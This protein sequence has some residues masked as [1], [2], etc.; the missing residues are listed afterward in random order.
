MKKNIIILSW[1][2]FTINCHAQYPVIEMHFNGKNTECEKII[3]DTCLD[4][5]SMRLQYDSIII[6]ATLPKMYL[7]YADS[8]KF[9][10]DTSSNNGTSSSTYLRKTGQYVLSKNIP[11]VCISC[12]VSQYDI[13]IIFIGTKIFLDDSVKTTRWQ[14]NYAYTGGVWERNGVTSNITSSYRIS[15]PNSHIVYSVYEAVGCCNEL[16]ECGNLIGRI[17]QFFD[18]RGRCNKEEMGDVYVVYSYNI[19]GK[20]KKELWYKYDSIL[21]AKVKYV[22]QGNK[23]KATYKIVSNDDSFSVVTEKNNHITNEKCYNSNGALVWTRTTHEDSSSNESMTI[24][25]DDDRL[26]YQKKYDEITNTIT[27]GFIGNNHK[28]FYDYTIYDRHG[29]SIQVVQYELFD[30]IKIPVRIIK[31]IIIDNGILDVHPFSVM[32]GKETDTSPN[33]KN[34]D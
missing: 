19:L 8:V 25:N 22:Y 33:I 28:T 16:P 9:I 30:N 5:L 21:I 6:T 3:S 23:K 29:D 13:S 17:Q 7:Q 18:Y 2:V 26:I 20:L 12:S 34:N 14:D 32:E 15:K 24:I 27:E 31:K 10:I 1:L 4:F 11:G